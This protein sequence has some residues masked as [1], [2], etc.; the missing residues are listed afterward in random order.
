[1]QRE[2]GKSYSVTLASFNPA[3]PPLDLR[4][5]DLVELRAVA[6]LVRLVTPSRA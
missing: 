6:D 4:V 2:R 5:A 1:M 3:Y